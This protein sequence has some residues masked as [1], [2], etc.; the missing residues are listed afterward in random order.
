MAETKEKGPT[1]PVAG[2]DK[3]ASEGKKYFVFNNGG[4]RIRLKNGPDG[5]ERHLLPGLSIE[6][7]NKEEHDT[8]VAYR[9]IMSGDKIVAGT[10]TELGELRVENAALRKERD[11]L[12]AAL[13]KAE[14]K[15][16]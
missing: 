6:C 12:Q 2:A 15:G 13:K 16:K 10:D 3:T 14:A 5:K 9:G 4:Q 7:R 8:L 1:P 11:E